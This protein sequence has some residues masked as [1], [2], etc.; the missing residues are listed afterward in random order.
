VTNIETGETVEYVSQKAAAKDL[1]VSATAIGKCFKSKKLLK[2]T[3]SI[4]SKS[5]D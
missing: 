5:S 1:G 2:K 3:F 4:T